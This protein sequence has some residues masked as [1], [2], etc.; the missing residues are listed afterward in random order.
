MFI[1]Y[2]ILN[3]FVPKLSVF[4][5]ESVTIIK[6]IISE[7]KLQ[8]SESAFTGYVKLPAKILP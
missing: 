6:S 5:L 8:L 1:E 2:T 7:A 4:M 3:F